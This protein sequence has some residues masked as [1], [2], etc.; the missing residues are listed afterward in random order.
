MNSNK[1]TN[2]NFEMINYGLPTAHTERK[3]YQVIF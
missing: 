3:S 2:T 1:L